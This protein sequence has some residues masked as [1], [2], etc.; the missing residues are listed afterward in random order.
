[1]ASPLRARRRRGSAA[2]DADV[3][4]AFSTDA[5]FLTVCAVRLEGLNE[6]FGVSMPA[7]VEVGRI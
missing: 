5:T 2:A 7:K 4:D 6:S 3:E 1:M